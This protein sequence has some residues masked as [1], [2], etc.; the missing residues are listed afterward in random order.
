M[1][2]D[3][4]KYNYHTHCPALYFFQKLHENEELQKLKENVIYLF[5]YLRIIC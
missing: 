2:F 3:N 5:I 4:V 1:I